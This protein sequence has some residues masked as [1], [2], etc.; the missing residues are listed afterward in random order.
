MAEYKDYLK[1]PNRK[2]YLITKEFCKTF[3]EELGS[4]FDYVL[5]DDRNIYYTT[6]TYGFYTA[7]EKACRKH[8]IMALLRYTYSLGWY[9]GDQFD[10][11]LVDRMHELGVI[12]EYDS[13]MYSWD[14]EEDL[15]KS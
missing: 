10:A 7:L 11:L 12:G 3:K 13:K 9:Q 1:I 6:S 4:V 14:D 2:K 15:W 5:Q 8:N